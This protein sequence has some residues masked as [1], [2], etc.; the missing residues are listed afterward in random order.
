MSTD[1]YMTRGTSDNGSFECG[2]E[3]RVGAGL[4]AA[5]AVKSRVLE[6]R[7]LSRSAKMVVYNALA[8]LTLTYGAE[9]WVLKERE[10]QRVQAVEARVLRSAQQCLVWI[11]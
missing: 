5:G 8:V 1:T 11:T 9:S 10:M 2:V 4:R 3:N 6:N 7:E